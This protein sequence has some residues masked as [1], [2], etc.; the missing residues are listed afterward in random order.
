MS[1]VLSKLRAL[2]HLCNATTN[3]NGDSDKGI[4]AYRLLP[5]TTIIT[6]NASQGFNPSLHGVGAGDRKNEAR[7]GRRFS[8]RPQTPVSACTGM[9]ENAF[10][11]EGGGA[12]VD[13]RVLEVVVGQEEDE[14]GNGVRHGLR[15]VGDVTVRCIQ[16][17]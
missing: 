6:F 4:G 2:L 12:E 15:Q 7:H 11:V 13:I 9:R 14:V 3:D 1:N 10:A 8:E 17:S 5:A 16:S